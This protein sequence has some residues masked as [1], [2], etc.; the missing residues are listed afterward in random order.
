MRKWKYVPSPAIDEL[1]RTAYEK[2]RLGD[3]LALTAVSCKLGWPRYS[4]AKRGAELGITRVKERVWSER[5]EEI[6]H[7]YG[8][9]PISSVQKRLALSGFER[10]CAAVQVKVTRL[11]I[12]QNLDGYSA[13]SLAVAFGVDVHKVLRWIHR[14]LLKAGRRGT[15]RRSRQGGDTWWITHRDVKRFVLRAPDEIDLA[16]VE[17]FWFLDLLTSGRICR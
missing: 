16:R 14:G 11:K 13:C 6:L 2:Q 7:R 8:H 4:I 9:L 17:K 15:G 10:S 12:K 5:E 1:I 3:R